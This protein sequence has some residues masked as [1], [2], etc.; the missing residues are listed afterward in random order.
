[1][2]Y[3]KNTELKYN[4]C[5]IEDKIVLLGVDK[6]LEEESVRLF[7]DISAQ[8]YDGLATHIMQLNSPQDRTLLFGVID[9]FISD[10]RNR[11]DFYGMYWALFLDFL[12][13]IK[14]ETLY[15]LSVQLSRIIEGHGW[16]E[17]A[18]Y[19]SEDTIKRDIVNYMKGGI[20]SFEHKMR[21]YHPILK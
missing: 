20:D 13:M 18:R 9:E 14:K 16:V 4:H 2:N 11:K 15:D 17:R 12:R 19:S 8:A 6:D 1:M 10:T 21:A 5:Y 7:E 3:E